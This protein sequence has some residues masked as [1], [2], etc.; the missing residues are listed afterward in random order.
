MVMNALLSQ[1]ACAQSLEK[2]VKAAY[3]VNFTRFVS[4]P[5]EVFSS[6]EICIAGDQDVYWAL[7]KLLS[8]KGAVGRSF[9]ARSVLHPA[10]AMGC[11][12][13]YLASGNLDLQRYW[14]RQFPQGQTLTVSDN[15]GFVDAGGMIGFL[16]ID[17][18]LRFDI[19]QAAIND[20]GLSVSSKLLSL[21]HRVQRP[22]QEGN[23]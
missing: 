23:R 7:V 20:Q 12:V 1:Q 15:P 6:L 16:I 10:Q 13:M 18:K 22:S 19:N 9:R 4:W 17:G 3:L 21:A 8:T 14:L 11:S 5:S 2:R